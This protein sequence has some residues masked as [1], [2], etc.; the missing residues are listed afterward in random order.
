MTHKIHT[1]WSPDKQ[2]CLKNQEPRTKSEWNPLSCIITDCRAVTLYAWVLESRWAS[3]WS[4][5]YSV[6]CVLCS[7][8]C[9]RCFM[10]RT[11]T[12]QRAASCEC[13]RLRLGAAAGE[14]G[15]GCL[16][17]NS[18]PSPRYP[19]LLYLT[20]CLSLSVYIVYICLY[21]SLSV[22]TC[23][24]MPLSAGVRRW[25]SARW[26]IHISRGTE[27]RKALLLSV[28]V[29]RFTF[30]VFVFRFTFSECLLFLIAELWM[31]GLKSSG[32][33]L[34]LVG[35]ELSRPLG[36]FCHQTQIINDLAAT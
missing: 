17:E 34:K 31:A 9:C 18:S 21:L 2:D 11:P 19:E 30:S 7:L 27:G 6:F 25:I 14:R 12:W 20:L 13:L 24:C 33:R 29:F 1:Q 22:S 5:L 23:L 35:W 28:F 8:C 4:V 36:W 3:V 15:V 32:V 16:H 26:S 10:C